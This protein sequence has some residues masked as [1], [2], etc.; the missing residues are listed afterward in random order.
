[1]ACPQELKVSQRFSHSEIKSGHT[2]LGM[3]KGLL[4]TFKEGSKGS[5][6]IHNSLLLS[7]EKQVG[8]GV[9]RGTDPIRKCWSYYSNSFFF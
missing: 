6:F 2:P 7:V 4:L 3:P 5:L 9:G 8:D 1:M